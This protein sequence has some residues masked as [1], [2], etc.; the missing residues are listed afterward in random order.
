M[1]K[2]IIITLLF[3]AFSA[4]STSGETVRPRHTYDKFADFVKDVKKTIEFKRLHKIGTEEN[5]VLEKGQSVHL[6]FEDNPA[7]I[8]EFI[9]FYDGTIVRL[10]YRH[11]DKDKYTGTSIT[12]ERKKAY[13]AMGVAKGLHYFYEY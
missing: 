7:G 1:K 8:V 12:P 6:D 13:R 2:L 10:I 4:E 11:T 5:I 9:I 3:A